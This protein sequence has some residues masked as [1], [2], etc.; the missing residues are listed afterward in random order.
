MAQAH[1]IKPSTA[2]TPIRRGGEW[3]LRA[4]DRFADVL[5]LSPDPGSAHQIIE[6]AC[7][8]TRLRDFGD[9]TFQEPLRVLARSYADE[10]ALSTFGR[11]A[12]RWD[13][14]RFLSNLL[15]LRAAEEENPSILEEPTEQP[16]FI[17]GLPR[18]GTTFLHSLLIED[19]SNLA[20]RCWQTVYP[21]AVHSASPAVQRACVN[22]VERQ[23]TAFAWLAP[24]IRSVHRLSARAPQECTEIT[25]HVFQ[26]LRFD[27]THRVPSYRHWVDR[28]G[29]LAA[30][31]FHRRFLQHLQ[32]RESARR[33]V[34]KSPDHVFALDAI[35]EVYPDARFVFVHRSPLEVLPS[36]AQLTEILRRP[37]TRHLDRREIGQQV[38]ECWERGANILTSVAP[39]SRASHCRV[40]HIDFNALIRNPVGSVAALY[41]RFG[42]TFRAAFEQ[43]LLTRLADWPEGGYRRERPSL[44]EYGLSRETERRRFAAYMDCFNFKTT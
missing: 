30:Y 18:S 36:V 5:G 44:E 3:L 25:A 16:I 37:F 43:R 15:L 24:E 26:S 31:R 34:L 42:L 38:S 8:L 4:A 27:T 35:Q 6:R 13:T 33:W 32:Y 19:P 29:H 40:A 1:V 7:H 20:V 2:R 14:L 22:K 41:E 21:C 28:A 9:N 11:M 10:A 23:L 12:A 39:A 17:T